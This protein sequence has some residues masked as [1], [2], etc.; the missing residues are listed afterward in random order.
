MQIGG[1]STMKFQKQY[2]LAKTDKE[3]DK[4]DKDSDNN[5]ESNDIGAINQVQLCGTLD[6]VMGDKD[7]QVEI[8][9]VQNHAKK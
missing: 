3:Q 6:S 9:K 5:M 1:T 8:T 4:D 7:A 2:V